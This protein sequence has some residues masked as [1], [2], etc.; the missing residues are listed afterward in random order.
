MASPTH[1]IDPRGERFFWGGSADDEPAT[2]RSAPSPL[3]ESGEVPCASAIADR[4][5]VEVEVDF[6]DQEACPETLRSPV[7]EGVSTNVQ[8]SRVA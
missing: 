2:V 6:E 1:D 8:R 5:E 3:A 4:L 7:S